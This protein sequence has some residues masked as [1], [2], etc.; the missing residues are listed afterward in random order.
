MFKNI[1][2]FLLLQITPIYANA[3]LALKIT[4]TFR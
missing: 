3:N 4:Q 1:A 2:I